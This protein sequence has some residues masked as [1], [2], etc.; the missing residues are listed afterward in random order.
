MKSKLLFIDTSAFL[1]LTLT[2]DQFHSPAIQFIKTQPPLITSSW[3]I[4]EYIAHMHF[5][6]GIPY[7][8][9]AIEFMKQTPQLKIEF[10]SDALLERIFIV[11][12]QKASKNISIVDI[13]NAVVMEE[14][15]ISQ[16]FAFDKRFSSVFNLDVV[17][18]KS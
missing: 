8:L 6:Y 11:Y 1:A 4:E 3:V 9:T 10:L 12:K 14:L 18:K 17:P 16:I 15:G 7:A 5:R 2:T 13:S